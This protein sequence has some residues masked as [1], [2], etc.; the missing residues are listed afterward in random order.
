MAHFD[1]LVE[2]HRWAV[3]I[4]EGCSVRVVDSDVQVQLQANPREEGALGYVE[5]CQFHVIDPDVGVLGFEH[6]ED[7]DEE[8][9][10]QEDGKS[11]SQAATEVAFPASVQRLALLP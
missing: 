5:V 7:E 4:L 6:G 10:T 2:Q 3:G 9:D 11:H 1:G 8:D